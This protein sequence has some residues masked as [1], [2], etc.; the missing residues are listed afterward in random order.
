VHWGLEN[1]LHWVKTS[2]RSIAGKRLLAGRD[3]SYM[4]KV[5]FSG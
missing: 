3:T 4:E 2:K 5:L 1:S